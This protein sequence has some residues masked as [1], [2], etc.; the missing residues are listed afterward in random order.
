L[1]RGESGMVFSERALGISTAAEEKGAEG[2]KV[3]GFLG[4]ID[5]SQ[6]QGVIDWEKVKP[7]IA[8]AMLRAGY[9][10]GNLDT[11]FSRNASEC[12]RLGI[13]FGV[14]W[15]SYALSPDMAAAEAGDCLAAAAPYPPAYPVAFDFEYDSVRYA[16][17]RGVTVTAEL[18]S[19][20]AEA[21]CAAVEKAG[22]RALLYANA[23]FLARY[24]GPSP[25][26]RAG[27]WLAEWP[28]RPDLAQPPR[29]CLLWQWGKTDCDGIS[30]SVDR[31][32][33]CGDFGAA[34]NNSES[35]EKSMTRYNTIDEVPDWGREA[36][37]KLAAAGALRG[38][39]SGLALSEDML[40]V[41]VINDRM[42]LYK[43]GGK[44]DE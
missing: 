6:F 14:Y 15:F 3:K 35:E 2:R 44:T 12:A 27:L 5:V 43:Q 21:F 17:R 33:C 9:G 37:S 1:N 38:N 19:A 7:Q 18:A 10:Q 34:D 40:R 20:I 13:P 32:V 24:F 31:D 8:F 25:P 4:G 28:A 41:L 23:D 30:G 36:V 22:R 29:D 16:M 42:G 11:C 39:D 26:G